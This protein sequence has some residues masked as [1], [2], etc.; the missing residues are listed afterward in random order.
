MINKVKAQNTSG[1][2]VARVKVDIEEM[3]AALSLPNG[4]SLPDG[5][6]DLITFAKDALIFEGVLS[7]REDV[8]NDNA[9]SGVSSGVVKFGSVA[10]SDWLSQGPGNA[11]DY[12]IVGGNELDNWNAIG[13][14]APKLAAAG[15]KIIMTVSNGGNG[16]PTRGRIDVTIMY[17]DFP[18]L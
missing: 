4:S 10:E 1:V 5:T 11:W 13:A 9:F 3:I 8:I 12:Y 17:L 6:Y 14:N 2:K 16:G 15:S 7:I 18:A